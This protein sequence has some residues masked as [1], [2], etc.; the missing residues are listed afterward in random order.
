M[1]AAAA[2]LVELCFPAYSD[3]DWKN[4]RQCGLCFHCDEQFVPD[5]VCKNRHLHV[6]LLGEGG[7]KDDND[8]RVAE[9]VCAM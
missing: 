7:W 3:A 8:D 4:H 1:E 9:E 2:L 6:S 5:H